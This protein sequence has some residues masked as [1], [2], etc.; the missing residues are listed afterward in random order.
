M[1]LKLCVS[2]L[3]K[4]T[5]ELNGII[6]FND[7]KYSFII[8]NEQD[9]KQIELPYSMGRLVPLHNFTSIPRSVLRLLIK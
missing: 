7:E 8:N 1:T 5:N 9:R 2:E 6:I 3:K 4:G